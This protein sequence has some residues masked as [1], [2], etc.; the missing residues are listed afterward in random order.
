MDE[1]PLIL[2]RHRIFVA[3]AQKSNFIGLLKLVEIGGISSEFFVVKT[4]GVGV[5]Q[6]AVHQL[7]L[8]VALQIRSDPRCSHC[9]SDQ[10]H[11]DKDEDADQHIALFGIRWLLR[12]G[13][14]FK[15]L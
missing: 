7:V 5:L 2:T 12:V 11:C 4:D 10:H 3:F 6:S 9:Q 15:H 14:I 8:F 1:P 13:A